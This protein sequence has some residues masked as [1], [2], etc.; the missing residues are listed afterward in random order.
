MIDVTQAPYNCRF[1]WTG[2]DATAT[3][4]Y[5]GLQAAINDAAVI[6]PPGIDLGGVV[7]DLLQLPRG[8]GLVSQKLVM[9]FGVSM[10]GQPHAY[11]ASGLKMSD[12]FDNNSHFIDLGDETTHLAAMGCSI[13][14]MILFSR[15]R[16]AAA[17]KSMIFTN[18]AQDTDPIV[19]R[20][21]IY[22]GN[23]ACIW[24]EKAWGGGT[25]I[26]FRNLNLHNVGSLNGAV[27][28]PLMWLKYGDGTMVRMDGIEPAVYS[29]GV[30]NSYGLYLAGG[31]FDIR[32]YHAEQI[33]TGA[34]VDLVNGGKVHFEHCTGGNDV[35]RLITI[36]NR[37][38]QAGKTTVKNIAKNGCSYTVLNG[39]PGG[40]SYTTD[41]GG[42]VTL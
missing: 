9:P 28:A 24:G 15:N 22:A 34:I 1:D 13:S 23:R 39:L 18:N 26:N 7:G 41:I 14:D 11:Y 29:G 2:S 42:E 12:N 3:D 38:S 20:C 8:M 27:S 4:N 25:L 10:R 21:R 40:T 32:G 6:V 35:D 17:N 5:A 31:N 19:G 33:W 16:E 36:N 37:P 30:P